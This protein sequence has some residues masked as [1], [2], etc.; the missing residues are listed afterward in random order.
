MTRIDMKPRGMPLGAAVDH[1]AT[2]RLHI[3]HLPPAPRCLRCL[4]YS[5]PEH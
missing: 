5:V 3:P 1:E 4:L 2:L